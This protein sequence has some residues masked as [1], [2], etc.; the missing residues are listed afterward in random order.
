MVTS[1]ATFQQVRCEHQSTDN[2]VQFSSKMCALQKALDE[3][4]NNATSDEEIQIRTLL[5]KNID[6]VN[7]RT[8]ARESA[9]MVKNAVSVA[10]KVTVEAIRVG[11]RKRLAREAETLETLAWAADVIGD[12]VETAIEMGFAAGEA[13]IKDIPTACKK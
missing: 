5:E 10:M 13:M 9:V 8:T 11:I 4:I 6:H 1:N 7:T 12:V 3:V 2:K